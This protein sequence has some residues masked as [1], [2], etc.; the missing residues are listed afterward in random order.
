MAATN[1]DQTE[2]EFKALNA[3]M[4]NSGFSE[5]ALTLNNTEVMNA[6]TINFLGA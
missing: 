1:L 5:N 6:F 3:P 4:Y 2:G